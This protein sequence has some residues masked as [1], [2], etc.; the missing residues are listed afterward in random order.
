M[1]TLAAHAEPDTAQVTLTVGGLTVGQVWKITRDGVTIHTWT[2]TAATATWVDVLAPFGR[3]LTYR[4]LSPTG[5]ATVAP[6]VSLPWTAAAQTPAFTT[7]SGK[8]PLLRMPSD[9]S[10]GAIRIPIS[11]Y[12]AEFGIRATVTPIIGSSTPVVQ[13]DRRQYK[14]FQFAVLTSSAAMRQA[15]IVYFQSG[16]VLHLRAPC[17]AGALDGVFFAALTV[18]ERIE[19]RQRPQLVTWTITA[20]QVDP[21]ADWG[22]LPASSG[23]RTWGDVLAQGTWGAVLRDDVTW[24]QVLNGPPATVVG[25]PVPPPAATSG[26]TW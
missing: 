18:S 23:R 13:S 24:G 21:V 14:R 25:A 3:D 11:D 19:D 8:W 17:V 2:A 1:A 7:N 10:R 12:S 4:L 16:R 5:L 9:P 6:A 15:L 26:V 22:V 20:Q